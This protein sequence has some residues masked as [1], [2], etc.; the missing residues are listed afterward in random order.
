MTRLLKY[1][2]PYRLP[3][4]LCPV[5][6]LFQVLCTMLLPYLMSFIV[7]YGIAGL[8]MY[9]PDKGSA[10]A[11]RIMELVY[12]PAGQQAAG[13]GAAGQLGAQAGQTVQHLSAQAVQTAQAFGDA[14]A[15]GYSSAQIIITFGVLMLLVSLIGGLCGV[16][17]AFLSSYASQNFGHDLRRDVFARMMEL[18]IQQTDRFTTG[19]LITRMTNDVQQTVQFVG[20]LIRMFIRAPLSMI[21]GIVMLLM[22][23]LNFG[24]VLLV[25][26]PLLAVALWRVVSRAVPMYSS[27]Q[28]KLD[29]VNATVQENL[30]GAR[31]VKAY[32]MEEF[33]RAR[34]GD[35][36]EDLCAFNERVLRL[37][38]VIPPITTIVMN[39]SI[40][41][42]IFIGGL[43]ISRGVAGMTTGAI[44]AAVTYVTQV[45][46]SIEMVTDMLQ[47]I[48]R[49]QASANRINEVLDV[50]PEILSGTAR[51]AAGPVAVRFEHVSFRY[52]GMS[53]EPV[54][55]D[56]S[57][58]IAQGEFLAIIGATGCG[59]TTLLSL[60]PRFYD[61][62]AGAVYVDGTPVRDYDLE[63]LR[64]KLGFVMQ[65][66]ELF[67]ES[68]E[69]NIRWG[70]P[71]ASAEEVRQAAEI[72]Q[73]EDFIDRFRQSFDTAVEGKGM[74]LSGGQKQRISIARAV[75][76]KPE[77]LI[78]DD[79]TSALDL[80]TEYNLRKAV[81]EQFKDTTMIVVAQRIASIMA[82]DRIAV[83]EEDGTIRH[84]APHE[85]LLAESSTYRSIY[86]SQIR[87]AR[88][89]EPAAA[90]GGEELAASGGELTA[91][92][93]PA[94]LGEKPAAES[95]GEELAASG[96]ELTAGKKSAELEEIP[97]AG[98]ESAAETEEKPTA[99]DLK[100]R[101]KGGE[102]DGK[103]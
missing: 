66:S 85:Q 100:T 96:E 67:G 45:V 40:I 60:I 34:F 50:K 2:K 80:E 46:Q 91:G 79:A 61:V 87:G 72:A 97:A 56:I 90:A 31:V 19:S 5:T 53:G 29:R 20:M 18:S 48:S 47:S 101:T 73:A 35:A 102:R 86:D 77:I 1:M 59:K 65:K 14:G 55:K 22:L 62:N 75:L 33:E 57:L 98:M 43:D 41:A 95:G 24:L 16:G 9:D 71:D 17:A 7:N 63:Y 93:K 44:M 39:G 37:M 51:P 21:I 92:K 69:D 76:R 28:I 74:S 49:A 13:S 82:A 70:R 52:P 81:R 103:R 78:L 6:V 42:V 30:N 12:G 84:C 38:A 26:M 88:E 89:E 83:M 99:G 54:L 68:L 8:S 15:D 11:A 36:N 64:K 94:E 27:V 4:L 23:D 3:A 25:A 32:S 10:A 58:D